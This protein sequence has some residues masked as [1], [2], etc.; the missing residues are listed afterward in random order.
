[1]AFLARLFSEGGRR[2]VEARGGV[3]L[4]GR[5]KRGHTPQLSLNC[6]ESERMDSLSRG[7]RWVRADG[8]VPSDRP[9]WLW[10]SRAKSSGD[11]TVVSQVEG[12]HPG[13]NFLQAADPAAPPSVPDYAS[14]RHK[15]HSLRPS[16]PL[17]S[18]S[19]SVIQPYH[20]LQQGLQP[21]YQSF[22]SIVYQLLPHQD[23]P[24]CSL[25]FI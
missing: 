10:M 9:S 5:C 22:R 17:L 24:A 20:R 7:L 6:S 14:P 2:G 4:A 21:R 8:G 23:T 19:L 16:S 18:L 15:K 1:M 13:C 11:S 12:R 25:S 3:V